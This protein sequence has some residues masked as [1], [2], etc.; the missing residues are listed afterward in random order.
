MVAVLY[1][2]SFDPLAYCFGLSVRYPCILYKE[3]V[4]HEHKR[5]KLYLIR[6]CVLKLTLLNKGVEGLGWCD[7]PELTSVPEHKFGCQ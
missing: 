1:F 2:N 7:G 3:C 4:N 6:T 5:M